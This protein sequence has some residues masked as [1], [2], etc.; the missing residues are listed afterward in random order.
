MMAANRPKFAKTRGD[1]T[2]HEMLRMVIASL[3]GYPNQGG[4]I[5]VMHEVQRIE[6]EAYNR[7]LADARTKSVGDWE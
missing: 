6:R 4:D 7:G 3:I 2:A 5:E 1:L